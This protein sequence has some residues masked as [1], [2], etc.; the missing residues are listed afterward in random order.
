M[1]KIKAA[2]FDFDGTVTEKGIPEM[3][4]EMMKALIKLAKKMPI[5]FCT[6]RN[7]ES[8]LRRGLDQLTNYLNDDERDEVLKN[9]YL[10]AEN[11]SVGYFFNTDINTYEEFYRVDWPDSLISMEKLKLDLSEKV[12][13]WGNLFENAHKAVVVYRTVF[14]DIENRDADEVY[15]FSQ[16]IYEVIVGYLESV[17]ENYENFLH[18]G[19]AGLGVLVIPADGDKDAGIK[20]FAQYFSDKFGTSF[21][22]NLKNIMVVGDRPQKGG[23]DY[24][25]LNSGLGT[26]F[27][28]GDL[29]EGKYPPTPVT[30]EDGERIFNGKGTLHI[31]KKVLKG[32]LEG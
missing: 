10:L 25:L 4:P 15:A 12:K 7:L 11:G 8:F 13:E 22:E 6:G 28:V 3:N 19:D 20:R 30:G 24:Y 31:I 26:V 2:I 14:Y 29:G 21:G 23:N 32:P 16:K 18:V 1:K 27:T 9:I 17:S 5:G